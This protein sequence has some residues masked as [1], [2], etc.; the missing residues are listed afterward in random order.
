MVTLKVQTTA[1]VLWISSK[2]HRGN[3]SS[4]DCDIGRL[5]NSCSKS[6]TRDHKYRILTIQTAIRAPDHVLGAISACSNQNGWSRH[7]ESKPSRMR[8][9]IYRWNVQVFQLLSRDYSIVR[10]KRVTPHPKPR[11]HAEHAVERINYTVFLAALHLYLEAMHGPPRIAS[12][13]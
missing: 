9:P 11:V 13:L 1:F 3:T 10:L 12:R 7:V 4:D 6:L 5:L 8:S 2:K